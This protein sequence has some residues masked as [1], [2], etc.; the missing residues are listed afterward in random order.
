MLKTC[1]CFIKY[2]D[3]S[4]ISNDGAVLV[5]KQFMSIWL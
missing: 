2:R 1:F 5:I 3:L 4:S